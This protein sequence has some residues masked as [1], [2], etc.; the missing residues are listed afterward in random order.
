MK[1]RDENMLQLRIFNKRRRAERGRGRIEKINAKITF[2]GHTSVVISK[3]YEFVN[4]LA[5]G[6]RM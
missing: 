1:T 5:V 4:S 2:I 6:S 3:Y